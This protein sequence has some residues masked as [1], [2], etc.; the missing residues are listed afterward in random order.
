MIKKA[1]NGKIE[2]IKF[3]EIKSSDWKKI[4]GWNDYYAHPDG[5]IKSVKE[6][7]HTR[8]RMLTTKEKV[9]SMF[10]TQGYLSVNLMEVVNGQEFRKKRSV[11]RLIALTFLPLVAGKGII[12]HIDSNKINAKLNNLE[13]CTH[14]E[15]TLH[16]YR[17]TNRIPAAIKKRKIPLD[18]LDYIKEE[19]EKGKTQ[20][21]LAEE[22]N[23]DP[24][25]IS[26]I[27]RGKTYVNHV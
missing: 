4:P 1:V 11:H 6:T 22:F 26:G 18:K 3:P 12:N 20:M 24:A 27:I 8:T 10:T 15:N 7:F 25:V 2:I 23:V 19:Y 14:S 9:L 16:S 17:T 21:K 5:F 13:W